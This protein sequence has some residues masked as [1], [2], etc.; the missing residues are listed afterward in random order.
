M[1]DDK[2]DTILRLS[3]ANVV[4]VRDWFRRHNTEVKKR[5]GSDKELSEFEYTVVSILESINV[6]KNNLDKYDL[7]F[8]V[9]KKK[10]L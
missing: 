4:D 8:V 7:K 3:G 1:N 2:F 5:Y 9:R 6:D 10:E